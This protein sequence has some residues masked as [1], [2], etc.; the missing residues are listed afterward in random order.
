MILVSTLRS[1]RRSF[2]HWDMAGGRYLVTVRCAGS[3]PREI[4]EKLAEIQKAW[5]GVEAR[6]VQ[7]GQG[8]GRY[9]ATL[10]KYLDAGHGNCLL[11]QVPAARI[12]V[13]ELA[14]LAEWNV[15]V[16]HHT[17]L[18][19]HWHA[20]IVPE[21]TCVRSLGDIIK[22][23]KSRSAHAIRE[24]LGGRGAVWQSGWFDRWIRD[25]AEWEKYVAYVRNNPV[26]A[27]LVRAWPDHPWT[28]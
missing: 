4:F 22:R 1:S 16:P 5:R 10:E 17:I 20:L 13:E 14:A 7:F 28:R 15:G 21:Q 8:P 23:V 26:K 24:E 2:P 6:S 19:N 12:V 27:G 25:D 11:R 3:L 18:P 9:F